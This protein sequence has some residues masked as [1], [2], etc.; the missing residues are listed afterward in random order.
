M[1]CGTARKW[2]SR[3]LDGELDAAQTSRLESHLAECESCRDA[4]ETWA[5]AGDVLRTNG[6]AEPEMTAEAM[7][8]A[9]Q[10]DIRVGAEG[11]SPATAPGWSGLIPRTVIVTA[12][13]AVL[14]LGILWIAPPGGGVSPGDASG[15]AG[16]ESVETDLSDATLI[17]YKDEATDA[18]VVWVSGENGG[19]ALEDHS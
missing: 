3:A 7:W 4:R 12:S 16:V 2:V 5:R 10:R 9:V 14:C 1:K 19:T 11:R 18:I 6:Q 8:Q 15:I 13:L 17:V